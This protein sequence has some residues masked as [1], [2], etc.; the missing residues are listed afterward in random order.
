MG[1]FAGFLGFC[2]PSHSPCSLVFVFLY[3]SYQACIENPH[4]DRTIPVPLIGFTDL[5][6]RRLDQVAFSRQ[7]SNIL[8][9]VGE[10]VQEMKTGQLVIAQKV[11]QLK[12][13]QIELSHRVLKVFFMG[14]F[15][16]FLGFCSPSHS[17]CSLVFVFLYQSYQACIENPHPDRTIP[18]PLIGF[19]D[20][21]R[22]RLDQ[23]AF[24]RQQ[25][26]ILKQVGE[27]VQEMKTGQ[28][29]IAQKVVQLKRKQIEL[30]H[31]VL[32]VS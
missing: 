24:S 16:G 25:S 10:F 3:Q 28:L 5:R 22:R 30:S 14:P 26:N 23:V 27:F 32:K 20:L 8:K 17:P 7:Q 21:R 29:V 6:R 12:R 11:V 9:Q 31:R 2:S 1:P 15:A 4:P 13:K 19:T 18:V